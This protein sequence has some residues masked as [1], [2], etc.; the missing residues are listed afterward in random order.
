MSRPILKA[1]AVLCIAALLTNCAPTSTALPSTQTP[2]EMATT[3]AQTTRQSAQTAS[4][5]IELLVGPVQMIMGAGMSM[6]DQG[7]PVNH[8]LEI[9]IY[10]K[11]S[12]AEVIGAR[13]EVRIENVFNGTLREFTDVRECLPPNDHGAGPHYGDNLYLA[14][15]E[16]L[17]TI[18]IGG[19]SADFVWAD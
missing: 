2:S 19:E 9:H 15:G 18:I 13:P 12:G 8:H 10:D 7:Q 11:A 6:T 16:Y 17:I 4:Y 3:P 14:D 1:F 5:R